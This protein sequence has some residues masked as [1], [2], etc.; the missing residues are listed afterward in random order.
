MKLSIFT[1]SEPMETEQEKTVVT[2]EENTGM[3]SLQHVPN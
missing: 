2:G 1:D 3:P